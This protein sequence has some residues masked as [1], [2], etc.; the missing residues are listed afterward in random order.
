M[1]DIASKTIRERRGWE[2]VGL[3][4]LVPGMGQMYCGKLV[5]GF[6]FIFVWGLSVWL[7][8]WLVTTF[9]PMSSLLFGLVLL[10]T[11]VVIPV[12]A[13]VDAYRL[14]RRTRKDYVLKEYNHTLAYVLI[15]LI[16]TSSVVGY[17]L[18]I[19][20]RFMEPFIIPA[21]SMCPT[22]ALNDR[23]LSNKI[24]Y[25]EEDPKRGDIVV[26]RPVVNRKIRY[27]KRIVAVAGDTVEMRDNEL[28]VNGNKLSRE[29]ITDIETGTIYYEN[30]GRCK[31][32]IQLTKS[33]DKPISDFESLTIPKHHCYVLGDN[34]NSSFDSRNFGC[35]PLATIIARADYLYCPAKNWSRFGRIR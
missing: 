20:D 8:P 33:K 1:N 28:Y 16:A 10:P 14:V 30:N 23:I 7:I 34:R 12:A 4:L 17:S 31:Y 13:M 25:Q 24:C 35:V 5:R 11:M 21:L 19:R 3:S 2:A 26:F 27:I 15:I 29:K 22:I 9:L 6:V 32:K 18:H